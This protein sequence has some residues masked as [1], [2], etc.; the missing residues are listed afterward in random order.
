MKY[1]L[2]PNMEEIISIVEHETANSPVYLAHDPI[3]L[4]ENVLFWFSGLLD[5][6]NKIPKV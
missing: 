2:K 6:E 3:K 4:Q 5:L 1:S